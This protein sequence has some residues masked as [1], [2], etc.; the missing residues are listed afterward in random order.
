MTSTVPLSVLDLV[1]ISSGSTASEALANSID[2]TCHAERLGYKRYWFAEHH[3]NPGIASSSPSMV[4]ALAASA[5]SKIRL[6]SGGMQLGHRTGLSVVE[7]FGLLSLRYP[8]RLDLGMGRS[9]RRPRRDPTASRP[10]P[11]SRELVVTPAVVDGMTANGVRVPKQFPIE[12]MLR[13]PRV[14]LQ[15]ALLQ[16]PN[17]ESQEYGE[18]IEEILGLLSGEYRSS[19]GLEAHAVPGEKSGV[20]VWILGSSG[21]QSAQVAGRNSLRFVASYHISPATALDAVAGYRAAFQPS[22]ELERPY[23]AVSADVVVG[24]DEE[25]AREHADA[26]AVWVLSIRKGDGAIE[27]PSP[28]ETRAHVWTDEDR[29]LVADR[30]ETQFVGSPDHV[31]DQLHRLQEVTGADELVIT[32]I[33]HSHADRVR[34]YELL[35]REW[36]GQ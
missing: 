23:V 1:P 21:G 27:F 19:E 8:G 18:Q 6:G 11:E 17:A 20:E 29:E 33:T 22:A 14:G 9:G 3:L 12:R 31:A 28:E 25:S 32:T 13:S 5:T 36:H 15:R 2:L 34:S 24:E 26:Y 35:A 4:I 7:E 10:A 30:T 16:Q